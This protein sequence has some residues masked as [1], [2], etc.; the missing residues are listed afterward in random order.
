[1][2]VNHLV[3]VTLLGFA[4][5]GCATPSERMR[6]SEHA[7]VES[8]RKVAAARWEAQQKAAVIQDE[9]DEEIRQIDDE[10]ADAIGEEQS[11]GYELASETSDSLAEAR[12]AVRLD[13]KQ[14]LD[15]IDT[16]IVE[17][18]AKL[19]KKG[20]PVEADR[21]V[22]DLRNRS[23]SVRRRNEAELDAATPATF[24]AVKRA[25]E[26]RLLELERAIVAAGD[27]V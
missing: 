8:D 20:S 13:A 1:M 18:R 9:A 16:E 19:E 25:V 22:T 21:V 10:S 27:R 6:E 23:E 14:R 15:L 26:A 11:V 24:D 2:W 4:A 7:R 3:P 17:L 5:V 12:A